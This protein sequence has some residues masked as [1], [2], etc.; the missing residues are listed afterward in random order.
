MQQKGK[1]ILV[2]DE[3]CMMCNNTVQ[4]IVQHDN[5]CQFYFATSK[6]EFGKRA[7][8]EAQTNAANTVLLVFDGKYYAESTAALKTLQ[9]LGWPY[10]LLYAAIAVPKQLRDA[11]Y[12]I[13]ARNRYR[14]NN[15]KQCMLP[16]QLSERLIV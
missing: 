12:R 11:I 3:D 15:G 10:K 7:H 8:I 9:L 1:A 6:S 14:W 2:F 16:K 13:V 5:S 4:W